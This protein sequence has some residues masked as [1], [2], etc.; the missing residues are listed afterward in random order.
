[1]IISLIRKGSAGIRSIP[2]SLRRLKIRE[3]EHEEVIV[4]LTNHITFR[5]KTIAA[6]AFTRTDGISLSSPRSSHRTGG[7]DC[8]G[9]CSGC[10]FDVRIWTT[11]RTTLMLKY[12]TLRSGFMGS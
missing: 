12:L 2:G 9:D 11:M 6:I 1:M 4:L 5:A 10:A 7:Y 8:C 3:E